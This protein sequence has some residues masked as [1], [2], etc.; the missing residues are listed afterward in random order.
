[1]KKSKI[2]AALAVAAT[3]SLGGALALTGCNAH[4]HSYTNPNHDGTHHWMECP[5]DGEKDESTYAE[6]VYDN[7]TDT[8]CNECDYVRTIEAPDPE[9]TGTVSGTVTAY[10]K[11]LNGV[12]V[13]VGGNDTL[14]SA[15]GKYS[16]DGVTTQSEVTVTFTKTGY[17][18][19][20]KKIAASAWNEKKVTLDAEMRLKEEKSIVKGVVRVDGKAVSGATVTLGD[21]AP[22]TTGS[23]GAYSFEVDSATAANLTL[24]VKHPDC[25][26]YTESVAIAAGSATLTKDVSLTAKTV[27]ELGGISLAELNALT[28]TAAEDY[29][30][31]RAPQ[32]SGI[33]SWTRNNSSNEQANEGLLFHEAGQDIDSGSTELKLF[34]YK[35]LTFNGMQQVTISATRFGDPTHNA[36]LKG[37][38]FPEVYVILVAA[39]GTV[40]TPE[41]APGKVEK[42]HS[43]FNDLT[44]TFD[45]AITGDYVLALGTTRGNRVA[46]E[47]VK[48]LGVTVS[49]NIT[50]TITQNN[51]PLS[52]AD[53]KF[54]DTTVQ[55]ESNGTFSIAV[56]V[57][58]GASEKITVSKDGVSMDISFNAEDLESGTYSIGE[59]ALKALPLP[60]I[61]Q[62]Q[63]NALPAKTATNITGDRNN[64]YNEFNN[65]WQKVGGNKK[66]GEGFILTDADYAEKG[67][68]TLKVFVYNKL[69]L[70][71]VQII[72]I[73]ARTFSDQN[74]ISG[75]G[76]VHPDIIL[77]L[78]DSNG[79]DVHIN[80]NVA[81]VNT[82]DENAYFYF[83]LD[84][85]VTGDYV[86][87]IGM[88]RG[89]N[90]A[91]GGIEYLPASALAQGTVTGTVKNADGNAVAGATVS[92]SCGFNIKAEVKTAADG[93][94]TL[95]VTLLSGS[96]VDV[97]VEQYDSA[98][99][100]EI[101]SSKKLV[102]STS[103]IESGACDKGEI[104][105][106]KAYAKGLSQDEIDGLTALSGNSWGT[107]SINDNWKRYG[108]YSKHGEG[109]CIE[110]TEANPV[111]YLYAKV[112]LGENDK[113]M[114][115]NARMFSR[116]SDGNGLLQVKVIK[117]DGTVEVLTPTKAY[118]GNNLINENIKGNALLN[119]GEY[120][121]EGVYDFSAYAGTSI[122]IVIQ[123]VSEDHS[124]NYHHA[125][126]DIS[127]G[128]NSDTAFGKPAVS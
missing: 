17:V 73:R 62:E 119:G 93:S 28:A 42:T 48:Y 74:F 88:A 117:E 33:D 78:I 107:D 108:G 125:I 60:G 106:V 22:V 68:E 102:V 13:A 120:Y 87:A 115:F 96:S 25:E 51:A 4:E 53:V 109:A 71:N 14:T 32:G 38:G 44:F 58:K 83:T 66:G 67:T 126:N 19:L 57:R 91:L 86:L 124:L 95:P 114:K 64:A 104:T 94:F 82:D 39:D 9:T 123:D 41:E 85:A 50:G 116:N 40:I 23:D 76:N 8:T 24:T 56:S 31:L 113:F 20:E 111:S 5:D 100:G 92:Y 105:L 3:M 1:M 15:T 2:L 35:K 30:F 10:G 112:T 89:R 46:I 47:S 118:N 84:S 97:W 12:K 65:N 99:A 55:T 52:G 110:I 29:C 98:N 21:K 27:S 6:H 7:A 101:V 122:V 75:H 72:K 34:A 79:D 81:S 128:N 121:T 59:R 18:T 11:A 90:L 61:T 69:A 26:N 16:L 63:L 80:Y 127:F 49:G 54:G 45:E 70:S 77:K 43:D 36:N 103:D 37:G